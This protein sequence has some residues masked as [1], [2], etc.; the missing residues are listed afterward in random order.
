[1]TA[2]ARTDTRSATLSDL[3]A[4]PLAGHEGF[5]PPRYKRG[6]RTTDRLLQSGRRLL[7]ARPLESVTIQDVCARAHV[8]TGAF[9]ARFD[10]KDSYFRAVQAM[11]LD[12]I[13]RGSIRTVQR[14]EA[15]GSLEEAV[16]AVVRGG[17]R[18]VIRIEGVLRATVAQQVGGWDPFREHARDAARQLVSRLG[19]LSG[20]PPSPELSAR[21]LF[22]M[23]FMTSTLVN[24]A[25]NDPGPLSVSNRKMDEELTRA[26]CLY[27]RA[28]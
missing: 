1:M 25:L 19:A 24:A 23:Q 13:R 12:E 22:A 27:V 16:H 28:G 14:V 17:R 5:T 18:T 20:L 4:A 21:I 15:A 26:F 10:G 7:R 9:Y 2:N 3:P 6:Q 8:T 11:A